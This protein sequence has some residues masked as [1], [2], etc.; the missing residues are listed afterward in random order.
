MKSA[1]DSN[2]FSQLAA[3]NVNDHV[4]RKG[5]FS[6]LSWPFAVSQL[7]QFDPQATWEVKRFGDLPYLTSDAGCFVE[8][9]VTVRGVTLSQIH[10]VL[11]G[12]N[13]P[14][15]APTSFEINTS[16][17]RCL[18]KAIALHGL[19][20]YIYA[21]EDLPQGTEEKSDEPVAGEKPQGAATIPVPIRQTKAIST[22]Q[23]AQLERLLD[24][25]KG[26][27]VRLLAYFGAET[28]ADAQIADLYVF[29]GS[30]GILVEIVRDEAAMAAIRAAW[31]VFQ[32]YLDTDTPP[33]LTDRDTVARTDPAWQLAAGLY[34]QAK[35]EA[36]KAAEALEKARE[37]LVGLASHASE[38]GDGVTVTRF[39]K[40]GSVD[41]KKVPELKGVDLDRYRK[42]GGVE[43]RVT[44]TK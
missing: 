42:A 43:V 14:I 18:V 25:T 36:D 16:L 7:R 4:E 1:N 20:L 6:Y 12:K 41:Y 26:D 24:E 37:R 27:R 9:A 21:G 2:Y 34:L 35:Q 13:R 30:D 33:P 32:R 40:Q 5:Q 17:Q 39:W 23:I 3:I 15:L 29:D 19:G 31:E 10:P 44:V 38:N 11:D 28:L 22:A 8:V